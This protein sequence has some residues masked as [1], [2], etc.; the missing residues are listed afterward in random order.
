LDLGASLGAA[1]FIFFPVL[2]ERPFATAV[3]QSMHPDL[4]GSRDTATNLLSQLVQFVK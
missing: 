4:V 2:K 1:I 3:R